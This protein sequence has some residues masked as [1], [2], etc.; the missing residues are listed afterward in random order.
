PG[1]HNRGW[2]PSYR[3]G[4]T[5]SGEA[6][7]EPLVSLMAEWGLEAAKYRGVEAMERIRGDI[8]RRKRELGSSRGDVHYEHLQDHQLTDYIIYNLFPNSVIT[9]GPDGVQLLRP[10]PHASDPARCHFDHWWLVPRIAGREFT[11]SPAGGPD[12]P[13]EDAPLESI[14]CGE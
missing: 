9:V 6:P 4:R 5:F 10:R 2:F 1:G 3:P 11:P 12:L 8:I 14:R 7:A 13:V